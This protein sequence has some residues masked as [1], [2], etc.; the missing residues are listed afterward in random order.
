MNLALAGQLDEARRA[1]QTLRR[2][3]PE[4]SQEWIKQNAVW[5]SDD[6]MKRYIEAFHAAGLK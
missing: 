5:V 1:L 6:A 3:A 2:L 4:I